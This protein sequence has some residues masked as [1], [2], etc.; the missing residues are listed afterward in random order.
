MTSNNAKKEYTNAL[1]EVRMIR[2][3]IENVRY[4]MGSL[5][6]NNNNARTALNTMFRSL[7]RKLEPLELRI[8]VLERNH[9][10]SASKLKGLSLLV[11]SQRIARNA[12]RK[13]R[14]RNANRASMGRA[15]TGGAHHALPRGLLARFPASLSVRR[16]ITK[17]KS[18]PTTRSRTS[19]FRRMTGNN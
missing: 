9:G 3:R 18:R 12:A 7:R 8:F 13:R 2:K 4:A 6:T 16:P 19:L 10:L 1:R 11:S 14:Q 15:L 17:K 5:N